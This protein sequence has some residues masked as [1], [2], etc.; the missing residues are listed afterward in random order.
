M[1]YEKVER[2]DLTTRV[3]RQLRVS[4]L[5]GTF[6]PGD[7]L[8]PERDLAVEFG[9]DRNTLRSAIQELEQQGLVERRQGSGCWVLN[10]RE[11]GS[12][13]LLQY[14]VFKP[15]TDELDPEIVRS[16]YEVMLVTLEGIVDLAVQRATADD[17]GSVRAAL[18]ALVVAVD[19]G[20]V[21][22]VD[23]AELLLTRRIIRAAH[24]PAAELVAN[25]FLQVQD[26]VFDPNGN[27]RL[28]W[29]QQLLDA[30]RLKVYR[31]AVTAFERRDANAAKQ[32]INVI[33]GPAADLVA[34]QMPPY[35]PR[36]ATKRAPR[37]KSKTA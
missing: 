33:A 7:R 4:V 36:R 25:T 14:L 10:Y 15:G 3:A 37:A 34:A 5:D 28:L 29:A 19:A 12:L 30:S 8:P 24:S 9:V 6:Q 26:A 22:D 23:R 2:E 11:T 16:M 32:M 18:D 20:E 27:L 35:R 13:E 31:R 21:E 1:A 17:L